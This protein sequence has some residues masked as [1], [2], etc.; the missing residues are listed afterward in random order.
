METLLGIAY[1]QGRSRMRSLLL[2][3]DTSFVIN[4][5]SLDG[6]TEEFLIPNF[7]LSLT[8]QL[9]DESKTG[10]VMCIFIVSTTIYLLFY[11]SYQRQSLNLF[12]GK[13]N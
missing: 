4:N 11:V 2:R 1:R 12:V 13:H 8:Q 7:L 9:K 3:R 6:G 5:L 10:L